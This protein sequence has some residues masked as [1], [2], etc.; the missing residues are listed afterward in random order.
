MKRNKMS[1]RLKK[2]VV[3]VVRSEAKRDRRTVANMTSWLVLEGLRKRTMEGD[4]F[5]LEPM[6]ARVRQKIRSF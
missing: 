5:E 2:E 1:I 4:V 6:S 3:Q